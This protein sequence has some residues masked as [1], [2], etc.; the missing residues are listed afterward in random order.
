MSLSELQL[1]AIHEA[2]QILAAVGLSLSDPPCA[3]DSDAEETYLPHNPDSENSVPPRALVLGSLYEPP[4]ARRFTPPEI[5][6]KHNRLTQ[7]TAVDALVDHPLG[8]L[9]EYPE[10]GSCTGERIAHRFAV[11][12]ADFLHPKADFQYSL[13]DKHGG[14]KDALCYLLR[15]GDGDLVSCSHVSTSCKCSHVG[16]HFTSRTTLPVPASSVP[17]SSYAEEEVF[18]KTLAFFC[19]LEDQGCSFDMDNSSATHSQDGDNSNQA[20]DDESEDDEARV[21]DT[22][23][24]RPSRDPNCKGRFTKESCRCEFYQRDCRSHL[25]LQNLDEY[26]IPYLAALISNDQARVFEHEAVAKHHGYGPLVACG[27]MASPSEQKSLSN[28]HREAD[29]ILKRGVLRRWSH[30]CTTTYD[31]YVPHNLFDCPQVVIVSRNPHS[32][33][34]PLPIKTPTALVAV[35]KS[36]LVSLDWKL[37][38]ATP[39]RIVLDSAFVAGLREQLDWTGLRDPVLSDLHPSLGNLDHVRRYITALHMEHFPAGTGLAGASHLLVK[40]KL[41]PPDQQYVRCVETHKDTG[42]KEFSLVVC[43]LMSMSVQLMRAKRLSI[44]TSFKRLHGWEEFEIE[45]WDADSKQSVVGAR[46]FTTSQTARAHFILLKRIFEIASSDTS[47]PV[48]FKHI[49]GDGFEAWIADA[50]KGQGLGVGLF[51]EYLCRDLP[52]YCPRESGRLLRSLG[53]YEHLKRFYRICVTHFKRNIHKMRGHVS[54]DVRAAMLS[55]ASSE[56]HADL[57]GTFTLIRNGGKK[58]SG[59]FNT[60]L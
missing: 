28:W 15:N 43:I 11:N 34:P 20:T 44:D 56:P 48:R 4:A 39:R 33:P 8:A 17:H 27:F 51:C 59:E 60:V 19:V 6:G 26:N 29:N 55:L 7:K 49:H 13:G 25:I 10:T 46:A 3:P 54:H 45:T 30:D 5:L 50:H 21:Y 58:A 36:L 38:D 57:E 1:T 23:I 37:A 9:V 52:G 42:E 12:P 24:R 40:H 32:H 2:K 18:M 47:L 35:L 53:P 16:H 31:I 41:L 22:R 14:H